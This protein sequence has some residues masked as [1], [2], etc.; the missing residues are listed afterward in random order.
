MIIK[1]NMK[2][3]NIVFDATDQKAIKRNM[4]KLQ[5]SQFCMVCNGGI[6]K[7]CRLFVQKFCHL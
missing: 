5:K 7:K 3:N 1:Y 6:G 4:N 2:I